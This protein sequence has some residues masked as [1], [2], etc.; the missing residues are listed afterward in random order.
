M[1]V[2]LSKLGEAFTAARSYEQ[3]LPPLQQ[4][5]KIADTLL[6][7]NPRSSVWMRDVSVCHGKL[8][9]FYLDRREPE[10]IRLAIEHLEKALQSDGALYESNP[11]SRTTLRDLMGTLHRLSRL[12]ES[13][14]EGDAARRHHVRCSQLARRVLSEGRRIDPEMR[15]MLLQLSET[16]IEGAID[17]GIPMRLVNELFSDPDMSELLE[18]VKKD[19][20]FDGPPTSWDPGLKR[21]VIEALIR[22][23]RIKL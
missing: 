13:I 18:E 11:S 2:S 17:G 5:L 22:A 4:S 1:S 21:E 6:Q 19:N 10:D 12:Y 16:D 14:Q 23:G 8:A 7:L 9:E 3:A 20:E 15:I